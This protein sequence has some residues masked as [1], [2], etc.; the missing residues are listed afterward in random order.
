MLFPWSIQN[1]RV[2]VMLQVSCMLCGL[3]VFQVLV[4]CMLAVQC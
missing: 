4:V 2:Y 3:S 1:F